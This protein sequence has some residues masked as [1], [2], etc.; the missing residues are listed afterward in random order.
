[1]NRVGIYYAYWTQEWDVEFGPYITKAAKLG[2]DVLE[3]NAGTVATM[4]SSQR[5]ELKKAAADAGIELTFCVG[6]QPKYDVASTDEAT[7]RAGVQYLAQMVQGIA[8]TGGRTLGG[9]IYGC[10]PGKMPE[11]VIDRRPRVEQSVRSLK[12]ACAIGGDC[13]VTLC[14]EVVNR[15]EQYIMNT[16]AESVD[17]VQ[18]VSHPNCKILLDSF[19]L[20]IEEDSITDAIVAAGPHLGHFHIGETNRRAPGRGRMPWNEIYSSLRHVNYG[21]V[22]TM[23][24]FLKPGGQVG[25]DI[26]VYR[27]LSVGIDLDQE[28][29]R[30]L[31]FTRKKMASVTE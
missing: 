1:M 25:R 30:A 14:V 11:G 22:V 12:E 9:I 20:N 18:Q 29:K 3:I 31:E 23:E 21:G 2:F 10:W 13:G 27:D 19:H 7:R 4:A 28:A 26:S 8:E 15:F 16:A 17:Y 24:P 5:R 6:L